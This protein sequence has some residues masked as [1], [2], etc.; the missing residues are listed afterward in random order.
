MKYDYQVTLRDLLDMLYGCHLLDKNNTMAVSIVDE[1]GYDD[2]VRLNVFNSYTFDEYTTSIS[3]E[4]GA[5]YY[6]CATYPVPK[7]NTKISNKLVITLDYTYN[8][9][10]GV[11]WGKS[12]WKKVIF[13]DVKSVNLKSM[14]I[15]R[16]IT[17]DGCSTA[18]STIITDFISFYSRA[19]GLDAI[20]DDNIVGILIELFEENG[21]N[22]DTLSQFLSDELE[23]DDSIITFKELD[24]DY[25]KRNKDYLK[26]IKSKLKGVL[27]FK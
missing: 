15:T 19:D 23:H 11:K 24:Y 8:L 18:D 16:F 3:L 4:I 2:S 22:E 6:S 7:E 5:S 13:E 25:V 9:R 14:T 1:N 20:L 26:S 17:G 12:R 10:D 21:I 27:K